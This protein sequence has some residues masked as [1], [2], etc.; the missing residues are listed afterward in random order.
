LFVLVVSFCHDLFHHRE[1]ISSDGMLDS[2]VV[3]PGSLGLELFDNLLAIPLKLF[4]IHRDGGK[5]L[6]QLM[7]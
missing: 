4:S 1:E 5:S 7:M 2:P 3:Q 6:R